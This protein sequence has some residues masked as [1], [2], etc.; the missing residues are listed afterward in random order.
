MKPYGNYLL[1]GIGIIWLVTAYDIYCCQWL[2]D[3]Q[4]PQ[5]AWIIEH[6][7]LWPFISIKIIGTAIATEWLRQLHWGYLALVSVSYLAL[8]IYLSV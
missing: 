1:L 8:A 5:A 7:G 6:C 2:V 4:N 3:E